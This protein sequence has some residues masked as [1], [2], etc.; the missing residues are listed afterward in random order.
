MKKQYNIPSVQIETAEAISI[1]AISSI[2]DIV[3]HDKASDGEILSK[4]YDSD[5]D[6]DSD[7]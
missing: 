6:W 1:M 7:W 2:D 5:D 3:I 4:E